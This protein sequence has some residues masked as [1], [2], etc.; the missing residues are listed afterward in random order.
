VP[1]MGVGVKHPATR[2]RRNVK[3]TR[4]VLH[5]D[6]DRKVPHLPAHPNGAWHPQALV[7]WRQLWKSPMAQEYDPATDLH[8]LYMLVL[9]YDDFLTAETPT[10]RQKAAVEVRLQGVRYGITPFD[11]RRLEWTIEQAEEAQDRGRKRRQTHGE[12]TPTPQAGRPDD[13][14]D[15]D[16]DDGH[17]VGGFLQVVQ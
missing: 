1:G 11:R 5:A 17:D 9:C 4:A 13:S 2:A 7:Y 6:P 16:G 10:Q 3:S 12:A 14:A 15:D 8:G